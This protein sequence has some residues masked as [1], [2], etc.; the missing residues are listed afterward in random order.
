MPEL[1]EVEIIR[2]GLEK[3]VV[4]QEIADVDV[5]SPKQFTGDPKSVIGAKIIG[6]RR[7]GKGL[8]I[9]LSNGFSIAVHV[10][11]T[12]Q[13]IYREHEVCPEYCD[14]LPNKWTRVV[15]KIKDQRSKTQIKT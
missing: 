6:I 8:V 2:R 5:L 10:K 15:F 4:G 3:Y 9:D 1:P 11:M 12:G 13:L 7:F 14:K